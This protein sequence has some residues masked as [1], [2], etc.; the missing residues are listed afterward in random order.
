LR[1]GPLS[2]DHCASTV[3]WLLGLAPVVGSTPGV[4]GVTGSLRR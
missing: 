1:P 2:F 4:S 3:S